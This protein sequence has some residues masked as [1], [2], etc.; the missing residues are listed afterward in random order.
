MQRRYNKAST[1]KGYC[2]KYKAS[3]EEIEDEDMDIDKG[4]FEMTP[5]KP[6]D[7]LDEWIQMINEHEAWI[8]TCEKQTDK[9]EKSAT[10]LVPPLLH[11]YLDVFE[12]KPSD[13]LTQTTG[14]RYRPN[15]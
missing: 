8:R 6:Y 10:E 15:R 2:F 11:V 14:S 7:T 9:K 1:T 13:A 4:E 3:V 5:E 12:K